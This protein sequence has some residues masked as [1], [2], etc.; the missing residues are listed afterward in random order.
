MA[1]DVSGLRI[2]NLTE[3][4]SL[5]N[6]DYLP[7]D[8]S[9]SGTKRIS[10]ANITDGVLNGLTSKTFTLDVGNRTI[11]IA[12]NDLHT[13]DVALGARIDSIVTPS[14]DP[15]L[16]EVADARVSLDGT[17]YASLEAR[18][19]ANETAMQNA[20]EAVDLTFTDTYTDGNIV[21][22]KGV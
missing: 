12:L 6:A 15:S 16:A 10:F 7:A 14:G 17:T 11:I 4:S 21:I 2:I 13:A 1:S 22:T 9:S 18:L 3:A 19:N 8:N 20:V 5:V